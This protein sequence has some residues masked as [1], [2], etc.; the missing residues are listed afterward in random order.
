MKNFDEKNYLNKINICIQPIFNERKYLFVNFSMFFRISVM[1]QYFGDKHLGYFNRNIFLLHLFILYFQINDKILA[2]LH[3]SYVYSLVK[4]HLKI[5]VR[6]KM[7]RAFAF[8]S[9]CAFINFTRHRFEFVLLLFFFLNLI[10]VD[11]KLR[12][13]DKMQISLCSSVTEDEETICR[14]KKLKKS[15]LV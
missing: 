6:F 5:L 1:M 14:K 11:F 2:R 15:N 3:C 12:N 13:I 10:I 9:F 4:V 7:I 8:I